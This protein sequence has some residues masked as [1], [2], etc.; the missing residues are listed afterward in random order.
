VFSALDLP[1]LK[2]RYELIA[3]KFDIQY[4]PIAYMCMEEWIH[5]KTLNQ[6]GISDTKKYKKIAITT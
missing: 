4:D 2:D 3:N 1:A 5:N 6:V